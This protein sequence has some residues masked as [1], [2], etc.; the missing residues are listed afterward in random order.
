MGLLLLFMSCSQPKARTKVEPVIIRPAIKIIVDSITRYNQFTSSGVGYA[1]VRTPQ[2]DR[3]EKL[4]T[5]ATLPELR[6]LTRHENAVVRCYAFLALSAKKDTAAFNILLT[7]LHDTARLSTFMGCIISKKIAGDFF[8][9]TVTSYHSSYTGYKLSPNQKIKVDSILLFDKHI[10]LS[11]RYN[12]IYALKPQAKYYNRIK[13]LATT[14]NMPVAIWALAKFKRQ[15]D[16]GIINKGFNGG[17][18]EDYAIRSVIEM[19]DSSFYPK[20]VSIFEREWK[21]KFYDY[22]KWELLYRA[23]ARYPEKPQTLAFFKRTVQSKDKFRYGKL[24]ADLLVAITKYPN[25]VFEPLKKQIKLDKYD[26]ED[27]KRELSKN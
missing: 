21:Q 9:A 1:G 8:L 13:E 26:M 10:T 5:T 20:L 4:S 17:G 16:I 18:T 24:D 6:A 25:P 11:A 12:L 14:E 22:E 23:L 19:P 2:W 3:Y 7:H 27:V 15:S